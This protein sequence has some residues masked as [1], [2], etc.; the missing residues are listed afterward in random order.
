MGR[1]I[2][3]ENLI[4]IKEMEESDAVALL[5]RVGNLSSSAEHIQAAKGIVA[6][7]GYIPLAID[8]AGAYIE[9]GRCD[10]N[11]YLRRFSLHCK[12]LMS[13]AT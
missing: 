7:L 6:E 12:T 3:F 11:K 8:Q 10:I 13:D 4:E 2:G 9:A 5:L 1:V